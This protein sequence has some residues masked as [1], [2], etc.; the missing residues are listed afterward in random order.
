ML[1]IIFAHA[2]GDL[3]LQTEFI[4]DNKFF[5]PMVMAA[6]SI[7]WAGCISVAL[8]YIGYY[9]PWKF[10]FLI[11]GHIIIDYFSCYFYYCTDFNPQMINFLDQLAHLCQLLFVYYVGG[12]V[13]GLS[14]R[15]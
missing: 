5:Y 6:H 8:K 14:S 2:I 15:L 4:G 9:K 7:I 1:W 3:A 12:R 10:I 11:I 13:E